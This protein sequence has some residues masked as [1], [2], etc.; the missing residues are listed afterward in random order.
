[1]QFKY[2]FYCNAQSVRFEQVPNKISRYYAYFYHY[3]YYSMQHGD[4]LIEKLEGTGV[5]RTLS[6]RQSKK[7]CKV[8]KVSTSS[9]SGYI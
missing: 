5:R 3:C 9:G 2:I 7:P 6:T 4:V 8:S 1:M